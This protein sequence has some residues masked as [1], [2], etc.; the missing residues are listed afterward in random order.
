MCPFVTFCALMQNITTTTDKGN[1]RVRLVEEC[2]EVLTVLAT[3]I[4]Y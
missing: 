4:N 2:Q 3:L 1:K